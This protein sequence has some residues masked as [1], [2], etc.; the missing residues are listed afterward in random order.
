MFAFDVATAVSPCDTISPVSSHLIAWMVKSH[1]CPNP[2]GAPTHFRFD[3]WKELLIRATVEE[4]S[5]TVLLSFPISR[6]DD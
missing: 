6:G 2:H 4:V 3:Q 5:C 1:L